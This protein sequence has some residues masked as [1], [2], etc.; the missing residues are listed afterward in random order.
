MKSPEINKMLAESFGSDVQAIAPNSWQ[1]ETPNFRLL[2]LLSDDESWLRA[3]IPITT[4]QEAQPFLEQLLEAN[5]TTTLEA[6][7]ALHQNVL[8]GVFE[9]NCETLTPEDFAEAVKRLLSLQA[10]GLNQSF[11]QLIENR[12]RQIIKVA[13]LQGQSIETTLKTLD[14]FYEEGL[15]GDIDEGA[16][17]REATLAAWRYQLERL[18][19]EVNS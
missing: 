12:I 19:P 17:A 3:L 1:I 7:Y 13:K 18:W 10:Q 9:H 5:F 14:R 4:A 8:W 2:I 6:R 15:M 11:G 16:A